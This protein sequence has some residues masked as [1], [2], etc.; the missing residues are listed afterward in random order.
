M[1]RHF[2]GRLADLILFWVT[3]TELVLLFLLTPTFGI[4]DWIYVIQHLMVLAIA[5]SRNPP[6]LRDYSVTS[7]IAVS[8]AYLY[9]YAQVIWLRWYPGNET[10]PICGLVL[11]T[12]AAVL[13]FVSLLRIGRQFGVRPALR[14]LVTAG[15]YRF[16]RHPMYLSYV[17]ADIGYN[18][19][20]WNFITLILVVVGWASLVYR[21]YAEEQMLS[22]HPGWQSYRARVRYRIFPAIW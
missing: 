8:V 6:K 1:F 16:V 18:L 3:A 15:P 9:P 13:S 20:E 10:W 11:V 19:Q 22:H 7:S 5:I 4:V 21:I 17:L 2:R 14:D 12:V